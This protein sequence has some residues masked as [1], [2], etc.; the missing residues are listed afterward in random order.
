MSTALLHRRLSAAMAL[1]ALMALMAGAGASSGLLLTAAALGVACWRLPPAEWSVWIERAAR[2]IIVA[3]CAWM[4]YVAFALG[5]DFMPAVMAMLLFLLAAESLRPVDAKNDARLYLLSFALLLAST[6]YY[7][8]LGFAL[9]FI[10]FIILSTLALMTGYLRRQSER[11]GVPG[12][13]LGRRM[14]VTIAAFSGVTLLVSATLFVLFPRLPRQWNVQGRRGGG[15][16]MAGFGDNVR[17]G[18]HG[19]RIVANPEVAFR[20]EFPDGPPPNPETT[21]WRGRSFDHFDGEEWTR[22]RRV[23]APTLGPALYARRWGGPMR[24]V[25]IFGG[26]AEAN[27]LFGSH[28]VLNIQ[29]RSAIRVFQD[30]TG[31]V[32]FVGSDAPVYTA[33]SAGPNPPEEALRNSDRPDGPLSRPYLQ[34]PA[35]LDPR[36]QRLADSLTAGLTTRI[37]R[38]RAIE[39]HFHRG[40]SYTLDL[41]RTARDATVEGFLF[42]RR[43]G[44]CEYYSTAMVMLLRAAGV[45]SRN[46]TGFLG[47]EWNG[48]GDYLAVT[49]NDAHSWV[50]VWMGD[51]GWVP[52]DPTPPGRAD[53][54]NAE[55]AGGW[56]W[57]ATLWFD[58]LEH[59]WYKWVIDYNLEKQLGLFSR[60]GDLFSRNDRRGSDGRGGSGAG[61]GVAVVIA[62]G[63][64]GALLWSARRWRRAPLTE[65]TRTYLALRRA[66]ARA[67]PGGSGGPMDF[68]ERL[69]RG[70]APGAAPAGELVSLYVRARFGRE[71]VGDVGR[72]R[73]RRLLDD[74]RA[75]LRAAKRKPA[76]MA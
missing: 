53:V 75:E 65:E 28:P 25:R 33:L 36:I 66:Y 45:P 21:Y 40:F 62:I 9:S 7:P 43:A 67:N 41:P 31:D 60:V 27:V 50:E 10:A 39:G 32:R 23:I 38:V 47:G 49:G 19:G 54:V 68:A 76:R 56:L 58:G 63:V 6:A 1:S 26:P 34:L 2:F 44:H 37:D 24:R 52:F 29:P 73:M 11:F 8:G 17:L 35:D 18:Q 42:R 16:V 64:L 20:V 13:R 12:V 61:R 30:Y 69:V 51:V 46:V 70:G 57:N 15:E 74:A 55:T 72:A 14:I 59:H 22:S 48:F 4:L 71:D 5:E 3:L